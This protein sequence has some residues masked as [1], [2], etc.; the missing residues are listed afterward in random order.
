MRPIFVA[1]FPA[2]GGRGGPCGIALEPG[3]N[4]VVIKL[5]GPKQ[6]GKALPHDRLGIGRKSFWNARF[7]ELLRFF[8]T[9]SEERVKAS[10]KIIGAG[11]TLGALGM[12][13]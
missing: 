5:L 11:N 10:R 8:L 7:V 6:A 12:S 1:A 9:P 4:V 2:F 13:R 3:A